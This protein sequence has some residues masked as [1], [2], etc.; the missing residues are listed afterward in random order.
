MAM[1][2]KIRKNTWILFLVIGLALAAFVLMDATGSSA[3][4]A[5]NDLS[6]VDVNGQTVDIRELQ[7]AEQ[8]LYA[9]QDVDFF[10]RRGYL[11]NYF[12]SKILVEDESKQ[13]GLAVGDDELE[14][15]TFGNNLS[16]IIQQ[17]FSDQ[18]TGLVD[19]QQLNNL[20]N[21]FNSGQATPE[22]S[23]YWDFQEKEIVKSQLETKLV[24]LID[25]GIYTPTWMVEEIGKAQ[26]TTA[27]VAFVKIPYE[28]VPNT[29]VDVSD[30]DMRSYYNDNQSLFDRQNE[31]RSLD[32]VV[33]SVYPTSEDTMA[34][35]EEIQGLIQDFKTTDND[36]TFVEGNY[37]TFDYVFYK[38]EDLFPD[39][40]ED[41]F[42]TPVDSVYGPYIEGN[43]FRAAK[44][45]NRM[46]VADSVKARHILRSA[47]TIEEYQ[48]ASLLIDSVRQLIETGTESFDSLA[49]K[50]SQD[51]G[52]AARGGELD[53]AGVGT[54]VKPFNDAV[55]YRSEIGELVT[56]VTDFGIHLIEVLDRKY[57]TNAEGIQVAYLN[58][59][60]VPS[61]VTQDYEYNNALD[62]LSSNRT[63]D[64]LIGAVDE[65][66]ALNLQT[67][68]LF[69]ENDFSL[70]LLGAGQ[71]ARDMIRFAF[72]DDTDLNDVSSEVYIFQDPEL[73]YNKQ[74]VVAAL[75][76]IQPEGMS[77]FEDVKE[78]IEPAVLNMTKGAYLNQK[79]GSNTDLRS[80]AQEYDVE[81]DTSS[82]INY[83]TQFATT[84][85]NE[86]DVIAAIFDLEEG[87][88]SQPIIGQG[89]LFVLRLLSKIE[90][91]DALN[92]ASL[93]TATNSQGRNIA[94][95]STVSS[96]MD[97]A[98]I[99]DMRSKFY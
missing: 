97:G 11:Y 35:R 82:N 12:T 71:T 70:G 48:A 38:Q 81:V 92:V 44:V 37:G 17:R 75:S 79:I 19:R 78:Q 63:L 33:F 43:A 1:I 59:P 56:V 61:E 3:G 39:V 49:T 6:V 40:A 46:I 65:N 64:D 88:T 83:T 53:Y 13:L 76:A 5:T 42:A 25:K 29:E 45:T 58:V 85:G 74:L 7:Q 41:L 80:L 18:A 68:A 95:N 34:L 72:E 52:S 24:N 22:I 36:T 27:E 51:P 28:D 4:L 86:P 16:P 89:G 2:Q 10:Q 90:N 94:R 50:F 14:E 62:L 26:N 57:I 87:E 30:A 84:I 98:K 69:E 21:A 55:F 67:S 54:F 99:K 96:L 60:I 32:Y 9:N 47:R 31:S 91:T 8:I 23:Q 20:R 15:L 66:P 73:Y 77:K 93:R